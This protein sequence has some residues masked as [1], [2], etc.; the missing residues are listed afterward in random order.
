MRLSAFVRAFSSN[1]ESPEAV[2]DGKTPTCSLKS[3]ATTSIMFAMIG[4]DHMPSGNKPGKTCSACPARTAA[5]SLMRL[6]RSLLRL[7]IASNFAA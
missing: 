1:V 5:T 3:F 4:F 7:R 6:S 2:I